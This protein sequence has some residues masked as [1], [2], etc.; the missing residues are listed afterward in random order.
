[1]VLRGGGGGLY[2]VGGRSLQCN[3]ARLWVFFYA[4]KSHIAS[5]E[6]HIRSPVDLP[7]I[8][9]YLTIFTATAMPA[10]SKEFPSDCLAL[11]GHF[12]NVLNM[13]ISFF[14][15]GSDDQ[16][17]LIFFSSPLLANL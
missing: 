2:N 15:R 10:D 16:Q 5:V 11:G 17:G 1:M 7:I 8:K 6:Y 13:L 4:S 3:D 14:L 9:G 12:A